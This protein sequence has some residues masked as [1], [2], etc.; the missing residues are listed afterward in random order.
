MFFLVLE[1]PLPPIRHP[2]M[3][4]ISGAENDVSGGSA[5][6]CSV[7]F[8]AALAFLF[9]K[10]SRWKDTRKHKVYEPF[11]KTSVYNVV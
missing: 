9:L 2:P 6:S 10:S 7:F 3:K 1:R 5:I 8:V 4:F 11:E